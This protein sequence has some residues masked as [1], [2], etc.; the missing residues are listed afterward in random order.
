MSSMQTNSTLLD[1]FG[2]SAAERAIVAEECAIW[3]YG[4]TF[5][6]YLDGFYFALSAL[7]TVGFGGARSRGVR[8]NRGEGVSPPRLDLGLRARCADVSAYTDIERLFAVG[9]MLIGVSFYAFT[10]GNLSA[11]M[12][13]IDSERAAFRKRV[14]TLNEFVKANKLPLPVQVGPDRCAAPDRETVKWRSSLAAVPRSSFAITLRSRTRSASS[15]KT[16]AP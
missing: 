16:S 11:I 2:C 14:D 3:S 12:S 10:I 7:T 8:G 13:N 15:R 5:S 4:N 6:V 1:E 9:I